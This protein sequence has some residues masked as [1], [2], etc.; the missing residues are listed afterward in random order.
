MNSEHYR[1]L[2]ALYSGARSSVMAGELYGSIVCYIRTRASRLFHS[3]VKYFKL[4]SNILYACY[5]QRR[6]N[7]KV[8]ASILQIKY[9]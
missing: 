6:T 4:L 2:G 9:H 3:H 5:S 7:F 8:Y 1:P